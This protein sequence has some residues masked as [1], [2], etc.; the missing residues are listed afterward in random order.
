[1]HKTTSDFVTFERYKRL[2]T[3][4]NFV[5]LHFKKKK[6]HTKTIY[7]A[8]HKTEEN[9]IVVEVAVSQFSNIYSNSSLK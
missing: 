2:C 6:C 4:V 7:N 9:Q 8:I 3:A 1:M 5:L